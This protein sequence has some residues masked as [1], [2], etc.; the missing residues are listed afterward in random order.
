MSVECHLQLPQYHISEIQH[1]HA[2]YINMSNISKVN[3]VEKKYIKNRNKKGKVCI[4]KKKLCH[5][6]MT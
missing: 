3:M 2:T 1:V 5:E 4:C 6:V